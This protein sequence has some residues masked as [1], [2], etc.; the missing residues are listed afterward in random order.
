MVSN[1]VED[2]YD[3]EDN[4]SISDIKYND[5][6]FNE[7]ICIIDEDIYDA[8]NSSEEFERIREFE[9]SPEFDA[10]KNTIWFKEIG[11]YPVNISQMEY[12]I[13]SMDILDAFKDFKVKSIIGFT[14]EQMDNLFLSLKIIN[15]SV[16]KFCEHVIMQ[17]FKP[18]FE[19][20]FY[21]NFL[22]ERP[23]LAN[24]SES[25]RVFLEEFYTDLGKYFVRFIKLYRTIKDDD[26]L[27]HTTS[28]L[29]LFCR[30]MLRCEYYS[31]VLKK[32]DIPIDNNF[33]KEKCQTFKDM[34]QQIIGYVNASI[35]H[36]FE[37]VDKIV[38]YFT[39]TK[40]S[41]GNI[42]S[43]LENNFDVVDIINEN[44]DVIENF[45]LQIMDNPSEKDIA[46]LD[47]LCISDYENF[48]Y[49]KNHKRKNKKHA[50][51]LQ[52]S[53]NPESDDINDYLFHWEKYSSKK[54]EHAIKKI[55]DM[56][57]SLYPENGMHN[58]FMPFVANNLVSDTTTLLS[59]IISIMEKER[60]E[61]GIFS[62]YDQVDLET[63]YMLVSIDISEQPDTY[64]VFL[65]HL[66]EK[67]DL[68]LLYPIEFI[69]RLIGRAL[70]IRIIY[71]QT[72]FTRIEFDN[73]IFELYDQPI[74][75]YQHNICKFY[76]LHP[77][78]THFLPICNFSKNSME[79]VNNKNDST[80]EFSNFFRNS[81]VVTDL[82]MI[83]DNPNRI[84]VHGDKIII[85]N[86]KIKI[87]EI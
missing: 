44:S 41:G 6:I 82:L 3:I 11:F 58:I 73:A 42:R 13:N 8:D 27:E 53:E 78:N 51:W 55:N 12:F 75:I 37:I 60:K 77:S 56:G 19:K 7:E 66:R 35:T 40:A 36:F 61:P 4:D 74:V 1:F 39:N 62:K 20:I 34:S 33:F 50:F 22:V 23:D 28:K 68:P 72:D 15:T 86:K 71:Y 52:E 16:V 24:K 38:T 17:Y 80:V 31:D 30:R 10:I 29:I 32:L 57:F 25:V 59:M 65:N 64:D 18:E 45:N 46:N 83:N 49:S 43:Y 54:K 85:N 76:I 9:R 79:N 84:P 14:S 87:Y 63:A 81:T 48:L 67:Q 2:I 69:L 70:Y 47:V 26:K 21:S 5:D